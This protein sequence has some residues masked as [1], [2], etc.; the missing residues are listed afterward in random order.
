M[1]A[2]VTTMQMDPGRIDDATRQLEERD[3]PTFKE[4]D[5]FRGFTLF[6]DRSS[7]KVFG[8][9]YWDS[10]DQ[11][12]ASEEQV[13]DARQRAADTGGASAGPQVERFEVALDSFVR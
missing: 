10:E 12:T 13:K 6:A 1:H 11:M 9:S 2:R 5:G 7:G 4:M 8:I 3:L